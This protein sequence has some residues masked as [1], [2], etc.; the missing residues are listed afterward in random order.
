M[1]RAIEERDLF[2]ICRA[3]R[4][5][6]MRGAPKGIT[7]RALRPGEYGAW[8]DL[9]CGTSAAARAAVDGF[10]QTVYAPEGDLFYERCLVAEDG[11]GEIMGS[12]MIWTAYA[13]FPTLHWL[14]V[15]PDC[16]GRG[17]GRALISRAMAGV[18]AGDYPVY[19]HTHPGCLRAIKLY[20][21]FGFGFITDDVVGRRKNELSESLPFLRARLPASVFDQTNFMPAPREFLEAARAGDAF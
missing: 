10:Y 18:A 15:R 1:T 14:K 9:Q 2:M 4:K 7:I 12:C 17:I 20:A 6:A 13:R 11:A 8:C 19:L 3:M 5:A 16:E 21:D